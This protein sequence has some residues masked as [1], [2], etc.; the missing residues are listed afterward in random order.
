ML[1]DVLCIPVPMT[2]EGQADNRCYIDASNIAAA[3]AASG[4]RATTEE[5]A[6]AFTGGLM[7]LVLQCHDLTPG[8][9]EQDEST[10]RKKK[11]EE[12]AEPPPPL[13]AQPPLSGHSATVCGGSVWIVGGSYSNGELRADTKRL[14]SQVVRWVCPSAGKLGFKSMGG[15]N[16][17]QLF[18]ELIGPMLLASTHT[19]TRCGDYVYVLG[20]HEPPS[21]LLW[22]KGGGLI[23]SIL[24][25]PSLSWKKRN[26]C[27]SRRRRSSAAIRPSSFLAPAASPSSAASTL[28][29][30]K[31]RARRLA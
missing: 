6:T 15:P 11:A 2:Q 7:G 19:A 5:A 9:H 1:V 17:P 21:G 25:V 26:E 4:M 20:G 23:L 29:W 24:H 14:Q 30:Q 27:I 28:M 10:G 31:A 18:E 12:D 22:E 13:S 8:G 16:G 3:N